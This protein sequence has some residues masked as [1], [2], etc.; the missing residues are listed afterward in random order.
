MEGGWMDGRR[1]MGEKG[2]FC[3]QGWE[4]KET[5]EGFPQSMI[6]KLGSLEL[7]ANGYT[8]HQIQAGM[9]RAGECTG[10]AGTRWAGTQ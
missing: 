9:G 10:R 5:G 8:S 7:W 6:W 3:T 4:R 2:G 1:L